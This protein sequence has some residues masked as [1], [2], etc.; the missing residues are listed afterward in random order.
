MVSSPLFEWG[1]KSEKSNLDSDEA[2]FYFYVGLTL[3]APN[4]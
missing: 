3:V 1:K 4:T 2:L